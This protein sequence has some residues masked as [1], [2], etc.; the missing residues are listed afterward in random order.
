MLDFIV[1]RKIFVIIE[2]KT[3]DI[4]CEIPNDLLELNIE[5]LK[6]FDA[7]KILSSR[8]CFIDDKTI[9]IINNQNLDCILKIVKNPDYE[10]QAGELKN[11]IILQSAVKLDN[12]FTNKT[13]LDHNH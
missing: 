1:V 7:I 11:K 8:I 5:G 3:N 13:K 2:L 10:K 9:K 12:L 6:S 4:I